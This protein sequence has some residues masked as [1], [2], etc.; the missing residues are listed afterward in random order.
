M[1]AHIDETG[2]TG[3]NLFDD[4]QPVFYSATLMT[5][6]DFDVQHSGSMQVI[7]QSIGAEELHASQMGIERIGAASGP[8]LEVS[9]DCGARWK[10][11]GWPT[12]TVGPTVLWEIK[13]PP[14]TGR[15]DT[16][17]RT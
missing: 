4:R 13:L 7:A 2:N 12:T 15:E 5:R 3:Q 6:E 16:S 1:Y 11:G 14:N 17:Y 9:E 8:L 10:R